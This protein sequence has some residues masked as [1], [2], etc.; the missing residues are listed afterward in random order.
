[1]TKKAAVRLIVRLAKSSMPSFQATKLPLRV[2]IN[3]LRLCVRRRFDEDETITLDLFKSFVKTLHGDVGYTLLRSILRRWPA[4][5]KQQCK[6]AKDKNL[7]L[8]AQVEE[9]KQQLKKAEDDKEHHANEMFHLTTQIRKLEE[10]SSALK[11]RVEGYGEGV[12]LNTVSD[13]RLKCV[14]MMI[15]VVE[16]RWRQE[17]VKR[18]L[19]KQISANPYFICPITQVPFVHPVIA[20]DGITYEKDAIQRWIQEDGRSPVTRAPIVILRDNAA[21]KSN[22]ELTRASLEREIAGKGNRRKV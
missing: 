10:Y 16:K 9:Q 14:G 12:V 5:L 18:E 11:N 3:L 1:M 2:R 7:M 13:F 15:G 8:M 4:M 19:D 21:L 6:K 22:I 17:H 20:S